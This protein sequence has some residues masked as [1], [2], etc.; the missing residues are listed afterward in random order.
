M[1]EEAI[2]EKGNDLAVRLIIILSSTVFISAILVLH[3]YSHRG[4]MRV[5]IF[6]VC[7][8]IL[9][10]R[11]PVMLWYHRIPTTIVR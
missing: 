10:Q 6:F 2:V 3:S 7:F 5:S 8:P 11:V 9:R 4:V 1:Y